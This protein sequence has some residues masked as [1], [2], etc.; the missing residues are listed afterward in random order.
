MESIKVENVSFTYPKGHKKA[1]DGINL[2]IAKGEFV[3]ICGK[4]GCGKTTLLRLLKPAISPVGEKE[5][6]IY[7]CGRDLSSCDER[8]LSSKIGFVMQNPDN[9]I[10]CDKVWH[11][12][13]FS[14][15]SLGFSTEEIRARVSEMASFFGIENWFYKNV[16][17]LSGGQ[18]QLLNLASVMAAGPEIIILDEPT[19]QLDP[20]ASNEFLTTLERINRELGT[21]VI[22]TE[23]RLEEVFPMADRVVVLDGGKIVADGKSRVVAKELKDTDHDMYK[24]L[25]VP[26][27]VWGAAENTLA[28]PMTVR[29]GR[30]W[31]ETYAQN[32]ELFDIPPSSDLCE[33]GETVIEVKDAYFKYE[34]AAPDVVQGLNLKVKRGQIYAILGGNGAGKTTALSLISGLNYPQRGKVYIEGKETKN[35]PNLY[36]GTLGVLPQNPQTLFAEKTVYEDLLEMLSHTQLSSKEK[37]QII[38]EM[39]SLCAIDDALESHPYD[40]S[41]GEMQRAALCK[42]LILAP[43]ILILD[44]PTKGMDAHFKITFASILRSLKK[45]GIT[46]VMVSHDVEFCSENADRCALFFDGSITSEACPLEFFAGKSFYTT[47]ANRMS[48]GILKN[49]ILADD[50]IFACTGKANEKK[51]E[52]IEINPPNKQYR[53]DDGGTTKKD[54]PVKKAE[55]GEKRPKKHSLMTALFLVASVALTVLFG[56][57]FLGNRKYYFI[58]LLII[59]ETVAAFCMMFEKRKP[60]AREIVVISVLCALSVAGRTA[61]IMVPQ[62]KPVLALIIISGICFGGEAGFLVGAVTA[63]VSNFF[64]GQGPWT[65]WQMFSFG[66]IGFIS[67]VVFQKGLLKVSKFSLSV[68]GFFVTLFIYGGIM[69]PASLFMWQSKI[70]LPMIVSAYAVGIPMDLVHALSTAVFLWFIAKPM[71]YKLDRIKTKY[72]LTI[73]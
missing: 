22:I 61:F 65:P 20:I 2:S 30:A 55:T 60:K 11:E 35:I 69:N 56:T 41:G 5:G 52:D 63:F 72:G 50:I 42:V 68:F 24:A 13:A 34:K 37:R 12:L 15:E 59:L 58:S 43:K 51:S 53:S 4:S 39:A 31:L 45:K 8:E 19:S 33:D 7:L 49:A 6:R 38:L 46:V 25:P 18:K 47:S 48:R 73:L 17:E 23:H 26:V 16:T 36:N 21:T 66:I 62:F 67:G 1:L 70:T 28:C 9:Q 44:E 10:V 64:F 29:E 40:L 32:H 27:R 14:L 57:F 71:I 3:T 54:L